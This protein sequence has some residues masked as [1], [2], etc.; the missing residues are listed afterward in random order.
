MDANQEIGALM[1]RQSDIKLSAESASPTSDSQ[2]PEPALCRVW[3][4][5]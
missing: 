2:A 1:N 5:D 4:E 3:I